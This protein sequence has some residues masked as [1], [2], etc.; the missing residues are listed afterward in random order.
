M[1]IRNNCEE[2][3]HLENCTVITGYLIIVLLPS[4]GTCDYSPYR[5]PKLR[6]ITDFLL[7]Y[8]VKYLTSIKD[9]FPNLTVI[10]GLKLFVNYALGITRM[11]DLQT[12]RCAPDVQESRLIN[13]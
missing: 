4:N 5:F 3:E 10:R 13:L 9:M 6:E 8:E 11:D 2:F 12:V 1:D 7:L